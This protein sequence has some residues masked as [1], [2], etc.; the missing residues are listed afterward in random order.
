MKILK[1][2]FGIGSKYRKEE[3]KY[4]KSGVAG[5]IITLI[6]MMAFVAISIGLELWALKAFH[7][8]FAA[9]LFISFFCFGFISISFEYCV[10]Y[11]IAAF[12]SIFVSTIEN[13]VE[14]KAQEEILKN[15]E[16]QDGQLVKREQQLSNEEVQDKVKVTKKHRWLDI[17]LAIVFAVMAVGLI[18][19]VIWLIFNHLVNL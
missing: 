7:D 2:I 1:W 11:S 14:K 17:V 10:M 4:R 13:F 3:Q 16:V 12:K 5:K 6:L 9:G 15:L 18:V 19:A 8:S